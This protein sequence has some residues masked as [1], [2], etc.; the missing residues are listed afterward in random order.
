MSGGNIVG[1]FAGGNAGTILNCYAAGSVE[2]IAY[3][4]GFTAGNYINDEEYGDIPG[5]IEKCYARGLVTGYSDTGG[6]VG[7]IVEGSVITD[8]YYDEST[9]Q[10]DTGKGTKETTAGMKDRATFSGWDFDNIWLMD[11]GTSR[12]YLYY[13]A[14]NWTGSSDAST[15]TDPGNWTVNLI[16][17]YGYPYAGVQSVFI[18]SGTDTITI[19]HDITVGRL[20]L[21]QGF[22][23]TVQLGGALNIDNAGEREGSLILKGGSFNAASG[24]LNIDGNFKKD[25]GVFT[26][27]T[28]TVN[29]ADSSRISS[30]EGNSTFHALQCVSSGKII[31]FEAGSVQTIEGYFKAEGS[32]GSKVK[33]TSS[34]PGYRWYI[35]PQATR[36]VTFADVSDSENINAT[37]IKAV[38]SVN[39]GNNE[40]WS[41]GS[42][43]NTRTIII[44]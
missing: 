16:E 20:K 27:G 9:G 6:L 19:P 8:S 37:E 43:K 25:G 36:S 32:Y 24:T 11:E 26:C 30:V 33:L 34:D 17:N 4:G 38:N 15:W 18:N 13:Q 12:P 7:A 39:S 10:S 21:G 41:F 40:N 22:G 42:F 1:G 28:S 5:T 14:Y 35:D 3:V 31:S 29:F 23:G 2:G 44:Y